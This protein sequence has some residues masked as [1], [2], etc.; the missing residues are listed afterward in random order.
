MIKKFSLALLAGAL[1]LGG[2]DNKIDLS[3]KDAVMDR[4]VC[5]RCKMVISAPNYTAQVVNPTN[6]EHYFFDDLGCAV[7]WLKESNVTWAD[8]AAFYITDAAS[9]KWL[10]ARKIGY[11]DGANTPMRFG[12]AAHEHGGNFT[13]Q[14]VSEKV[15]AIK[16]ERRK[17]KAKMHHEAK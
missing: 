16:A 7:L 1:F 10:D 13:I 12:F 6:G 17:M 2:C 14:E 3:P 8:K 11:S 9:G 4:E 5:H 15:F